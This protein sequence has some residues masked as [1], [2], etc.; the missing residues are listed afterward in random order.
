MLDNGTLNILNQAHLKNYRILIA[1][2]SAGRKDLIKTQLNKQGKQTHDIATWADFLSSHNNL[3]VTIAPI[4][5][6]VELEKN[7]LAIIS[8]YE[9]THKKNSTT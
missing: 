1:A 4:W 3:C 8:E 5:M 6:G 7:Q 9:L 2:E